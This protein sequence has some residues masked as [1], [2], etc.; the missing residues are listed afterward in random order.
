MLCGSSIPRLRFQSWN[1]PYLIADYCA[2]TIIKD[3][4]KTDVL[5]LGHQESTAR[6]AQTLYNCR[7]FMDPNMIL[8]FMIPRP[9]RRSVFNTP[10]TDDIHLEDA[11]ELRHQKCATRQGQRATK[12]SG[13]GRA[14]RQQGGQAL[15]RQR[16]VLCGDRFEARHRHRARPKHQ[17]ARAAVEHLTMRGRGGL[18]LA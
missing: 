2:A 1:V 18:R 10:T 11:L 9:V 4:N 5:A 17:L 6:Q 14:Q 3:I 16:E 7:T 15:G 12:Y 13:Q 8:R